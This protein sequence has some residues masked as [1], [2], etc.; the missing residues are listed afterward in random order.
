MKVFRLSGSKK[1][2]RARQGKAPRLALIGCGAIA[3]AYYLPALTHCPGILERSVLVDSNLARAEQ[4]AARFGVREI[5]P[6]YRSV[7]Q[8]IDGAIVAAPTHLHYPIVHDLLS[9]GKPVLCEKPLAESASQARTLVE[10]ADQ[11]GTALAV[12]YLQ[13]LIPSFSRVKE[14][15]TSGVIGEVRTI[16]Y[17]VGEE[18]DWPTS[19][20]FYFNSPLTARGVLRDRGAHVMDHICW[21]LGRKPQVV[22]SQNDSFGGSEALAIIRFTAGACEGTVRL[23]WLGSFPCRYF[24]ACEG[25]T[26]HGEIYD[27]RGFFIQ[28]VKGRVRRVEARAKENTKPKIALK[29]I[30]NFIEVV[31]RGENPLISGGEV[32]DSLHFIDECYAAG[33]RLEMPWYG[34]GEV[35]CVR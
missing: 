30:Q 32:L 29:V 35:V 12:N 21:W 8:D 1:Q 26:I 18:F 34:L 19:S 31:C 16:D 15:L 4:M 23:S 17:Q 9:A 14:F 28:D 33:T 10:R 24:L 27:Y 11:V 13:R 25:G 3:E 6:D 20:G 2:I 5:Q 7:I 22:S